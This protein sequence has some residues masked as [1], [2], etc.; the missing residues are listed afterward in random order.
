MYMYT[1][2]EQTSAKIRG[3]ILLLVAFLEFLAHISRRAGEHVRDY[4]I[5]YH[6]SH[7]RLVVLGGIDEVLSLDLIDLGL[8]AVAA[9][10]CS[11]SQSC[12]SRHAHT[13]AV[14]EQAHTVRGGEWLTPRTSE[15]TS[16]RIALHSFS[17]SAIRFSCSLRWRE[18]SMETSKSSFVFGGIV[19]IGPL[20]LTHWI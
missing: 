6:Q 8:S 1:R 20:G 13:C 11:S 3:E 14:R 16:S 4:A 7:R 5:S 15:S 18:F 19:L 10:T 9:H 17:H 12:I 2:E